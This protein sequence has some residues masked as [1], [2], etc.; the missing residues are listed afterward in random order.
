MTNA[1]SVKT[2]KAEQ[3]ALQ[4]E[5]DQ[6]KIIMQDANDVCAKRKA[7]LVKFNRKYGRVIAMITEH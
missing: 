1:V 2:I 5:Y 7:T 4:K 3:N 6:A